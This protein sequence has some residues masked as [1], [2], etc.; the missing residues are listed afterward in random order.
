MFPLEH[1][2]PILTHSLLDGFFL[3]RFAVVVESTQDFGIFNYVLVVRHVTGWCG[4]IG[5]EENQ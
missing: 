5:L 1:M 2:S 4:Q 3:E